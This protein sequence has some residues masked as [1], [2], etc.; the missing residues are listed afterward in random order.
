MV[1]LQ[2]VLQASLGPARG[3]QARRL[4]NFDRVEKWFARAFDKSLKPAACAIAINSPGWRLLYPLPRIPSTCKE[5]EHWGL[6]LSQLSHG[7]SCPAGGSAT[8]ADLIHSLIR[9]L[10]KETGIPV[11]SFAEDVA[12]SGG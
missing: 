10:S 7:W 3:P 5:L 1:R 8:Q 11:F 9:R 4:L 2:G 6:H 12:A